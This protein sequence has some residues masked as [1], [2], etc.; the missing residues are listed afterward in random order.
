MSP[1]KQ[2]WSHINGIGT[3]QNDA[4]KLVWQ[5]NDGGTSEG[6]NA[7]IYKK[8][9]ATELDDFFTKGGKYSVQLK[10]LS[11]S[12]PTS[13]AAALLASY[14]EIARGKNTTK[15]ER[16]FTFVFGLDADK[17]P[18]I[19]G[20]TDNGTTYTTPTNSTYKYKVT[21]G[22]DKYNLYEML[23]DPTT[24]TV[25]LFVNG[26]ERISDFPG[27]TVDPGYAATINGTAAAIFGSGSSPGVAKTNYGDVQL[28]IKNAS[29]TPPVVIPPTTPPTTP[30]SSTI[31]V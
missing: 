6:N 26:V 14:I 16:R 2:S 3:A 22:A 8:L 31:Q 23:Y 5:V 21:G 20:L 27:N 28:R 7:V 19:I 29:C 10:N 24:D 17:T 9:V 30:P 25:D 18:N 1:V 4:G 15:G 13:S 11:A 12:A